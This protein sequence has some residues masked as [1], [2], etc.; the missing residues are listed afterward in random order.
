VI[1]IGWPFVGPHYAHGERCLPWPTEL[2]RDSKNVPTFR[3]R[4]TDPSSATR[5]L[6]FVFAST[7][8]VAHLHVRVCNTVD[9]WGPSDHCR[10]TIQVAPST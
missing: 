2:P 1:D 10:I 3:T 7:D 9:G 5:Q 8:L 4:K 6:D